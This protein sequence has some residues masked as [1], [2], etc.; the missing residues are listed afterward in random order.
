MKWQILTV[1]KPALRYTQTGSEEYL[2]RLSKYTKVE[3]R[4]LKA[5]AEPKLTQS[6][7]EASGGNAPGALRI[8]LDERGKDL[9]TMD[10]ANWVKQ[11]ELSGETKLASILIGPSDGHSEET[12]T[13]A[14]LILRLSSFTLQHE[15]ALVVLLEQLYRV[16]TIHAGS[17]YHREG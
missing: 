6:F 8:V 13:K 2:K 4:H 12:R 10:F 16:Y 7:Y 17:P 3:L 1:G 14:D 15:L 11:R 9:S 5:Q